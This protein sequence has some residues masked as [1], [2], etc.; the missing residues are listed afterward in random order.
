MVVESIIS[1]LTISLST[2]FLLYD[3]IL[4]GSIISCVLLFLSSYVS[5]PLLFCWIYGLGLG[6]LSGVAFLPALTILWNQAPQRKA[7]YTG[8]ALFGYM[9][10]A[11][12]F[13]IL[14]TLVVNP[15]NDAPIIVESDGEED[16]TMYP[17][18]VSERV[19]MTI[20]WMVIA[21][22]AVLLL[23]LALVPRAKHENLNCT[24]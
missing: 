14:F 20:R 6:S 24:G 9:I 8:I 18:Y 17:K 22:L 15:S 12:P 4:V 16:E 13:G 11:T 7:K 21:Y 5:N 1:V 10:G 19:P 2:R 23:G 3:Q